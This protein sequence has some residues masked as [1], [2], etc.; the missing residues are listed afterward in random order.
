MALF[1]DRLKRVIAI[2]SDTD[3]GHS[4]FVIYPFQMNG[5]GHDDDS[6]KV[7]QGY[8]SDY[9]ET[10]EAVYVSAYERI[11]E[12]AEANV[13]NLDER[14]KE[15]MDWAEKRVQYIN[16]TTESLKSYEMYGVYSAIHPYAIV[17]LAG[18][19]GKYIDNLID[20]ANT[21]KWYEIDNGA[22]K[23]GDYAK[24]PTTSLIIDW[25]KQDPRRR[26]PYSFSDFVFCKYWN[27]IQN[28]R[29][30][31]LRRYPS[32]VTD[33]A[34]PA[35][36]K[37][38]K[39]SADGKNNLEPVEIKNEPFGPLCTA[40][41]YFGEG[42]NNILSDIL[43]FT[44]GYEWEETEGDVW[45][46]TS[47]QPEEGNITNGNDGYITGALNSVAKTLGLLGDLKGTNKIVPS[48]AAGLPPDPYHDGPYENRILGPIN[49]INKTYKR[50]RGL[51][52]SQ[53]GLTITFDYV[54]RPIANINNKAIMLDLLA[55]IMLMTSS[56]GTFFG[57]L[58]RYRCETPA[59]YPWRDTGI[60]NNLYQ[61]KL[62]GKEGAV[63]KT[64]KTT[65][66]A[67]NVLF[68]TNFVKDIL[69]D[70]KNI[71]SN[72]INKIVGGENT[73][74][75]SKS[76][77]SSTGAINKLQGTMG[78]AIAAK[79][80]KGAVI[81]YI[82]SAKAILTGDP[83][84]DWH[85]TIGNPLNPIATIGNLIVEHSEIKFS[86]ELGPDDFPIG[87]T[88]TITL[89][90]G[91]GRDRDAVESMFNRGYGRIY[92]LPD[93][94]KSSADRQ[95]AVDKATRNDAATGNDKGH[96]Q[97]EQ[98]YG[99]AP[100]GSFHISDIGNYKLANHGSMLTNLNHYALNLSDIIPSSDLRGEYLASPWTVHQ[101]L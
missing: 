60:L 2:T 52:F 43:K 58:H 54:A 16:E 95:T 68:A 82:N 56:S 20:K 74:D 86:D 39:T 79:Y 62:F 38:R 37:P 23:A 45:N 49:V 51:T 18:G 73:G 9:F 8:Y 44:V 99:L 47:Q 1:D 85:L 21:R 28:N 41:T 84:G 92:S 26:F 40:V 25:G 80:L 83:I 59:V 42:T 24:N 57:G 12:L 63:W 50:K 55:N 78:R 72:I 15:I 53:D 81:P 30:I 94:F 17:K 64:L 7:S 100:S 76:D 36:Y 66:S 96:S 98:W 19:G 77:D 22:G 67:D 87:F 90:H 35:N 34:E 65:F 27:K 31:T 10:P 61:G 48:H 71:A 5:S 11:Q 29:M 70:I 33:N 3:K 93:E 89:K 91:M 88:A 69:G 4:G 97:V 14:S 6:Y 101:T 32:P 75:T 13:K 46:I